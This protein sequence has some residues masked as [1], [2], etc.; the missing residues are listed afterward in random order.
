MELLETVTHPKPLAELLEA[1][2]E[3]YRAGH[4]WVADHE[5]APEVGRARH[6]RAGHDVRRVRA[7]S[8]GWPAREGLVLRY[9]AD[10]YRALRQTVPPRTPR[11]RS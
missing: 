3:M 7:A 5:L 1:A 2:F 10:A 11:P 8:T 9:L 6:V 4:P